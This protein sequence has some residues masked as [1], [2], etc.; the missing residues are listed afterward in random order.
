M[1]ENVVSHYKILEKLGEGGMGV[2]YK[3]QDLKLDRFVA[4]KFLP[5]GLVPNHE[6][7]QRFIQEAKAASALQHNNICTIHDIDETGDGREFIVMDF[8]E[9][10]T[11]KS[12][13][14]RG[15]LGI[16]EAVGV[17]LQAADGLSSAH[18]HGIVHRDIKPANVMIASSGNVKILDFG[19]AKLTGR[20]LLT[21][22]GSTIGTAAYMSPEQARGEDVDQRTDI[23]SLGVIIYEM[24]AGRLPFRAEH[25]SA[26]IYT[27][28][29]EEY[30]PVEKVRSDVPPGLARIVGK[31]LRKEQDARYATMKEVRADLSALFSKEPAGLAPRRL[32]EQLKRPKFAVPL[33]LVLCSLSLLLYWWIDRQGKISW[34]R[35]K[36]LDQIATLGKEEQW[37]AV[38]RLV[39]RV[40][41]IIPEDAVFLR[42]KE[43]CVRR[44]SVATEPPGARIRWREYA[45]SSGQWLTLGETPV[46][47]LVFPRGSS[48]L[49]LEKEGFEQSVTLVSDME[50]PDIRISLD[51]AGTVPPG[52]IHVPGGKYSLSIPGLEQI[53]S[54]D[55]SDY[56]ID[57]YEVTN[58]QYK[59]F[60]DAG[61]YVNRQ[62]WKQPFRGE[63]GGLTWEE[64]MAQFHDMT[65]RPGPA[66]WE[67]GSCPEGQ[68][69]HPV[70]GVSWY[71]AVAYA[72][73]AGKCLP[74]V[75]HWNVAAG[76][77]YS[78]DIVSHS[79]F[80]R[81]GT[82]AVGTYSGI[83]K[84]DASD[85]AGNVREWCWNATEGRRYILG[86]GWNDQPYTFNDAY[87]QDPLDR[88]ATNGF[89]CIKYS[90]GKE[91]RQALEA[92]INV[93][94][95]NLMNEKPV[96]DETFRYFRSLYSY[97]RTPLGSVIE[98]TDSTNAEWSVQKISYTAAYGGE[99]MSAYLFLPRHRKG[100]FQIVLFFPG[101]QAIFMRSANSSWMAG[102][103]DFLIRDGR[104]VLY[105]LY[106]STFERGDGLKT[107]VPTET[108]T[109]RDHA[110]MWVKDVSR[111][112]DYLETRPDID[113]SKLAYYGV[114]WGG[115]L[116]AIVPALETRIKTIVLNVAGLSLSRSLPEVDALNYVTRVKQPVLMLNGLY[117]NYFP[118][119]TSMKP[120]FDL[121]G[122]P[123]AQKESYLY[124]TGHA[125]PRTQLISKTL[126]WLDRYLGRTEQ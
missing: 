37:S 18:E 87:A 6:A 7:R 34:A 80:A 5:T 123:A 1:I 113:C 4:L 13:I 100:P 12:R 27:I 74:T 111:S 54:A 36:A 125:V 86:G 121:L 21:G 124:P 59:E 117:D 82:A 120:M 88:S 16:E 107:D 43:W 44:V 116:G 23:W 48:V 50:S 38:Y 64:A 3:A 11:L 57:R 75:Y 62:F 29:H 92:P 40:E 93:P 14:E 119:Q 8:Y 79:N 115:A 103:F 39:R 114:S 42:L 45:D 110:I 84:F 98:T 63:K 20:T 51:P 10:E 22:A 94:V 31:M 104:A 118:V 85:M 47:N 33:A 61:G 46:S 77:E 90:D 105:P 25:E 126:A 26:I 112:I 58:R 70:S 108:S 76:T 89:R 28:L 66:T 67:V 91:H 2:V 17:A 99:R 122:T 15:L 97:D 41:K 32:M 101:S 96:S 78:S 49:R 72:E 30:D 56:F 71:E 81:K 65:G 68:A 24:L 9:G 73:Y 19:V 52:M 83:S 60:V 109:Y 35:E 55:V 53:E 69:D 106:K 95:R 102:D